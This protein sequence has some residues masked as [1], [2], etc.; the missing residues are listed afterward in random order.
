MDRVLGDGDIVELGRGVS[1]EAI[2][3]PGHTRCS[4][5]FLVRPDKVL[6]GGESLGAYVSPEEIQAQSVS[7]FRDYIAS[8]ERIAE[9]DF[10]AIALP[11][12]GVRRGPEVRD[13]AR[14]AIRC[15]ED[16]R[17]KV[18]AGID[19]GADAEQLAAELAGQLRHGLSAMQPEKAFR[20]NL[21][22]MIRVIL[23]ERAQ[24]QTG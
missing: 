9:L 21:A 20:I 8:L 5:V 6:I 2:A 15:A 10:E 13:H 17:A 19:A 3:A 12:H 14:V 1:I 16:F 22:S 23:A 24:E 4:M 18:L 11:H 7:S